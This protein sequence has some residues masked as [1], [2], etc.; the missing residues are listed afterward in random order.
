MK[1]E[2]PKHVRFVCERCAICCG[3]TEKKVRAILLLKIEAEQI[4]QKTSRGIDTFAEKSKG[5]EPY[6]YRMKKTDAG[7]CVF[8]KDNSCT[9]YE[10]RPLI[11]RFYPFQLTSTKNGKAKF[12]YTNECPGISKGLVLK[13]DFFE[14]L[15]TESA[16]IMAKDSR[17]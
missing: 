7:K 16:R 17:R 1:F 9:I 8:L 5:T 11:C 12:S 13:K 6:V 4:S 14:K 3:D 2:Y 10:I 15:F